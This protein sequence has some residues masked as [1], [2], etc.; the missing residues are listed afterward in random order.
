M[1]APP[2]QAFTMPKIEPEII[3]Q[4]KED[5]KIRCEEIEK[6]ADEEVKL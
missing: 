4:W 5:F 3:K 6:K 2:V 1:A